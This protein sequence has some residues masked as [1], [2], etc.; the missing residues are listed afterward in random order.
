MPLPSKYSRSA[1]VI[2]LFAIAFFVTG[3]WQLQ[4]QIV[5]DGFIFIRLAQ[6]FAD[7]HGIVWN[8]GE[9]AT[10]GATNFLHFIALSALLVC[11]IE[12]VLAS[13]V[14][15]SA[16]AVL[17]FFLVTRG[18][19][20]KLGPMLPAGM[21]ILAI[22]M[23]DERITINAAARGLGSLIDGLAAVCVWLAANRQLKSPTAK[24][25]IA[26]G[27]IAFITCIARPTGALFT[28]V[29]YAVLLVNAL[30]EFGTDKSRL[31]AWSIAAGIT[32]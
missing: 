18:L 24:N 12:P 11:G 7:G 10:E 20:E 27:V 15:S 17:I 31:R 13:L 21:A 25:A 29:V 32:A 9:Q 5:D 19:R 8:V 6:N 3:V 22:F 23:V 16:C 28:A 4:D 1:V 26:L 2:A 14:L 30:L